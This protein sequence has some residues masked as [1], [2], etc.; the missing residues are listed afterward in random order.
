MKVEY[1]SLK[2]ASIIRMMRFFV[3]DEAFKAGLMVNM[4]NYSDSVA[5]FKCTTPFFCSVLIQYRS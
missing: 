5:V 1:Y 3:G 2:G 4:I